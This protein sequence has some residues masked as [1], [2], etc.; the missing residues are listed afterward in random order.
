M[1]VSR[2]SNTRL[3]F[4]KRDR[5]DRAEPEAAA[6]V[7]QPPEGEP[8]QPPP[9]PAAEPKTPS[10]TETTAAFSDNGVSMPNLGE[11]RATAESIVSLAAA[12]EAMSPTQSV[13]RLQSF[14]EEITAFTA[15]DVTPAEDLG[16]DL[17]AVALAPTSPLPAEPVSSS[18]GVGPLDS[19]LPPLLAIDSIDSRG[20]VEARAEGPASVVGSE[21]E[22]ERSGRD[23]GEGSDAGEVPDGASESEIE[24]PVEES[25]AAPHKAANAIQEMLQSMQ[26][27]DWEN[28]SRSQHA[29]R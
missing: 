20:E 23:S 12:E 3:P 9:A 2:L 8:R 13:S 14:G 28:G 7:P 19:E 1:L 25:G 11:G 18:P 22:G 15:T 26:A 5:L 24:S 27:E 6:T 29:D 16:G 10:A 17:E 4:F 21:N